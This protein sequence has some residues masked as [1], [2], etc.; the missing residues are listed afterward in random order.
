MARTM[1]KRALL[2]AFGTVRWRGATDEVVH[3]HNGEIVVDTGLS[4]I[5]IDDWGSANKK[6]ETRKRGT[7]ELP[8]ILKY[9]PPGTYLVSGSHSGD[10]GSCAGEIEITLEGGGIDTAWKIGGVGL[11]V[12]ALL[13]L[14]SAGRPG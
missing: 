3:N 11:T 4:D 12:L 5:P 9:L 13:G 1:G 14:I 2:I 6:N 8:T 10:E 7:E